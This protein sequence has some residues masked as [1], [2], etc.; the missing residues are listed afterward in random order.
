MVSPNF[1]RSFSPFSPRGKPL[2][3][4][5]GR[6]ILKTHKYVLL[7]FTVIQPEVFEYCFKTIYSGQ[8]NFKFANLVCEMT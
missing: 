7:F 6:V 3:K 2:N 5:Y 8:V 1:S 4:M